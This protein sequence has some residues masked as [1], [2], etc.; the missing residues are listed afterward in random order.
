MLNAIKEKS[1]QKNFFRE[2]NFL[3]LDA[4]DIYVENHSKERM[5]FYNNVLGKEISNKIQ[6]KCILQ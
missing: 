1:F 2:I 3:Y 6:L 4:F 5:D